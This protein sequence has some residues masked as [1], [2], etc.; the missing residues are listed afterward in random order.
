MREYKTIE[1]IESDNMLNP[2]Y[3]EFLLWYHLVL[4]AERG[5]D[6]SLA[7]ARVFYDEGC[8]TVLVEEADDRQG[9]AEADLRFGYG[10]DWAEKIKGFYVACNVLNDDGHGD[11]LVCPEEL[12]NGES[13]LA[14]ELKKQVSEGNQTGRRPSDDKTEGL[15]KST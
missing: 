10:F 4:C 7:E 3:R 13:D 2:E 8:R 5:F 1:S 12:A 6:G 11:F 15:A 9:L 14:M